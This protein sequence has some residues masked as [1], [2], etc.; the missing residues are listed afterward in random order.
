MN[1]LKARLAPKKIVQDLRDFSRID[2]QDIDLFDVEAGLDATLNIVRNELKYKADVIKEYAGLQPLECVGAQLNQ[3]FLN[4]LVNAAQAIED[5]GKI[6]VRTGYLDAE[7]FWV[8]VEDTGKG[9]PE[10]IQ[11][12]IFDPFF[13]TKPVGTGTGLGLSLSYQIIQNH[14]GRIELDSVPGRGTRFRIYLPIHPQN[15]DS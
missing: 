8:E 2:K 14:H 15:F 7:W 10:E 5:F 3:I 4:L 12:K 1:P 11:S 9:I 6:Y 13:T